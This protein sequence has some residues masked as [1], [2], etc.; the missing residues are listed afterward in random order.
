MQ[1]QHAY[2]NHFMHDCMDCMLN[3]SIISKLI[4]DDKFYNM[5]VSV[6]M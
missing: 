2:V 6:A 3:L 4:I 1:P 5:Q